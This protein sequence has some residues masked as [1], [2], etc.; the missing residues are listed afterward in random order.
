MPEIRRYFVLFF[1]TG[2]RN[3]PLG[4][5]NFSSFQQL[6]TELEEK[7]DCL[8][9]ECEIDFWIESPGGD[10]NI[11][12]KIFLELQARCKKWRAVIPDYAK[13]AATLLAIGAEEIHMAPSAEI[14]PLDAQIDHPDREG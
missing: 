5:F 11:S 8:S 6:Q 2:F 12:Y 9:D 14:G 13:S 1:Q 4:E 3:D 10:A 7:I